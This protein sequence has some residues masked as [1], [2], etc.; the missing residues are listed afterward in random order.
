MLIFILIQLSER[1]GVGR[2]KKTKM[3]SSE[4]NRNVTKEGKFPCAVCRRA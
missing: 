4:N 1:H 3:I 2:V